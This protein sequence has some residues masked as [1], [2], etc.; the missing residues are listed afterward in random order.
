MKRSW[1]LS[2][3]IL[4]LMFLPMP[5]FV[6]GSEAGV[7]IYT[8][9]ESINTA[10]ENNWSVKAKE[11]KVLESEYAERSARAGFYPAFNMSYSYTRLN[12]VTSVKIAGR[13]TLEFGD[14]NSFQW[15]ATVTQPLFTGFALTSAH[16]L[17]KLGIDQSRVDVELAKLDLALQVKESYFNI[18]GADKAVGVAKSAVES[19]ESH[20]GVA[21]NFY[22]VGMIPINDVLKAEVEMANAQHG[23]IRAQNGAK[24]ARA[25]FGV[26]L[27]NSVDETFD[28]EDI[29]KYTPEAPD[30]N[31]CLEKALKARPEIK[32]I[33]L[34]TGQI[35]Q[36]VNL[37]K[38]KYYPEAAFTYS[39]I[40]AGD[41]PA[42]SGSDFQKANS[43]QATLGLSWTFWD[44]NKTKSSVSQAESQK[45]QVAKT[46]KAIEDG[47]RLEL[48]SA[49]LNLKEAEEK[50]PTA[51]KAVKQ[52]EENLRVSEERYKAQVTTST[53]VLD[54]QTLLSQARMNYYSALYDHNLARA[55]LLRAVGEY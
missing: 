38:S 26:L 8:L 29:L 20:L 35:D 43:W 18:L 14:K 49:I 24:L 6:L 55:T 44:W 3:I 37:A 31:A 46:R 19:L 41:T 51:E 32:A 15:M 54:A 48:K 39:Y 36:Q 28:V 22:D 33:D 2:I 23:L 10:L 25:S 17:A 21:K 27:S 12:E 11:E 42:V 16:E 40:K 7:K 53:E 5:Q 1:Y 34:T 4:Y 52:A 47:I 50:I 9:N 45:L 30:F 13:G